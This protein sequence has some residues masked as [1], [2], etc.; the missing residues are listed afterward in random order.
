MRRAAP[1]ILMSLG[2]VGRWAM[3]QDI[4]S[5][6]GKVSDPSDAPVFGAVV[7]IEDA[8]GNKHT[9]VTDAQGGFRISSLQ[10]GAYAVTIAAAGFAEWNLSN[11][12]AV[13]PAESK[14][15]LAV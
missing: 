8:G 13:D 10:N 5:I 9:T 15:L 7:V 14:L 4:Y 1:F 6:Q 12:P 3:A 11:V 2:L